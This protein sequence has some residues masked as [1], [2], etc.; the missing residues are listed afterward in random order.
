MG[1]SARPRARRPRRRGT[2]CSRDP[3]SAARGNAG[4]R[5][6]ARARA[7]RVGRDGL[8]TGTPEALMMSTR[9]T[10]HVETAVTTVTSRRY[11]T[12]GPAEGPRGVRAMTEV[13][14]G[15]PVLHDQRSSSIRSIRRSLARPFTWAQPVRPGFASSRRRW[16]SVYCSRL[17]RRSA[18][19]NRAGSSRRGAHSKVA[20]LVDGEPARSLPARVI[21]GSGGSTAQPAPCAAALGIIVRNLTRSTCSPFGRPAAGGRRRDRRRQLDRERGSRRGTR[22][23]EPDP[24]A[25][26]VAAPLPHVPSTFSHTGGTPKPTYR[27]S[28]ATSPVM[29]T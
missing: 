20:E 28:A 17:G 2:G 19:G 21:R 5:R 24:C 8:G 18:A 7:D 16:R 14:P 12:I 11:P 25:D 9:V 15:R 1:G 26:H 10:A 3:G 13:E 4:R 6:S 22:Q 27:K 29:S 23:R